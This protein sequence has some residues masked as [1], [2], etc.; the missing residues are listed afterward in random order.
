MN[1]KKWKL[2]KKRQSS[3]AEL[4]RE[5]EEQVRRL[6]REFQA[7]R[8]LRRRKLRRQVEL[9]IDRL[10]VLREE[11]TDEPRG[12][13]EPLGVWFSSLSRGVK[14]LVAT[15]ITAGAV[16]AAIGSILAL[17]PGPP[18]ELRAEI[19][20]VSIDRNVTLDDYEASQETNSP[21]NEKSGSSAPNPAGGVLLAAEPVAQTGTVKQST[22]E[23]TT[24]ATEST[25]TATEST[26][27]GT[28]PTPTGDGQ[29][30]D[31]DIL[32]MVQLSDD[33]RARLR[34]GVRQ[35]L[36]SPAEVAPTDLGKACYT[37]VTD[38]DCGLSNQVLYMQV[39]DEKGEPTFVNQA[40]VAEQL[41]KLL[42]GTRTAPLLSGREQ[43]VGVT[44]NF[45]L[46][47]T[48]FRGRIVDVRWALH[49]D[50]SGGQVPRDWLKNQRGPRY[51]GNAEKDSASPA[52]WVPLPRSEGVYFIRLEI[53]DEDGVRLAY[54][55]TPRFQ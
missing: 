28:E 26:S 9:A 6:F 14:W 34:A 24:T 1:G 55:D 52:I 33:A 54:A 25:S 8:G 38:P 7:A 15:V 16:A 19:S 3:P 13:R 39:V 23:S 5:G 4:V 21:E 27:T 35:A 37:D 11:A 29:A 18:A 12:A 17:R 50:A 36:R 49:R 45:R 40:V 44:I 51:R 2:R 47:L 46:S 31:D 41:A 20:D 53:K 42:A 43:P 10:R 22:T 48:G 32:V 30:G